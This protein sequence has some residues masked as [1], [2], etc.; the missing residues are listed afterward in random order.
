MTLDKPKTAAKLNAEVSL[1]GKALAYTGAAVDDAKVRYRV[2]REVR[3]P[4]WW[5]WYFWWRQPQTNSQEIA[6]GSA[7]TKAD[8]TFAISF[9]AKP[10][11]SVAEADEP[12]FHFT[13]HADVTDTTGET[14]SAQQTVQ[15]RLHRAAGDPDRRRLASGGQAG[16][17]SPSRP[18]RWTAKGSWPRAR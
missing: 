17:Q 16:G 1:Q 10:D 2:V 8:G 13:V 3:Y 7:V 18:R 12:V 14:R 6:H 11:L 9:I 15:R 4:I 5:G